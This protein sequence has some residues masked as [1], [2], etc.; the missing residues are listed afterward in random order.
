MQFK[1]ISA[2]EPQKFCTFVYY[3]ALYLIKG[4]IGL[5]YCL[6]LFLL[7]TYILSELVRMHLY[8]SGLLGKYNLINKIKVLRILIYFFKTKRRP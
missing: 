8:N 1:L 4:T 2:L 3:G 6:K 5:K 7:C